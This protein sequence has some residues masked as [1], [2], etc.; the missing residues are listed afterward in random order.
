M[1][2][3]KNISSLFFWITIPLQKFLQRIGNQESFVTD[4]QVSKALRI[5]RAGDIL[6]SYESGRPTSWFIQ[7]YYDHA[8]IVTSDRCVMEA[9]GDKFE[10]QGRRKINTGGVRKVS[11]RDWL[12]K[13]D[14]FAIIRPIYRDKF[15]KKI[16]FL[17]AETSLYYQGLGYDYYF[18]KNNHK[19]YCSELVFM[20]YERHD[21]H[22]MRHVPDGQRILPMDYYNLC[23]QTDSFE[24]MFFSLKYEARNG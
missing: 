8:A 4:E 11:L 22:F 17:A 9:V 20:C 5:L 14:S 13:K 6:L 12:S 15:D 18:S 7:G 19:V 2:L 21:P 16:N 3:L 1:S 10:K 24:H 23:S